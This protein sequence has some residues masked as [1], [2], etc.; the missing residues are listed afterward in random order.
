MGKVSSCRE[1]RCRIEAGL[2][3]I[4]GKVTKGKVRYLLN[5]VFITPRCSNHLFSVLKRV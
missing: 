2:I 4:K 5:I 1:D 3:R